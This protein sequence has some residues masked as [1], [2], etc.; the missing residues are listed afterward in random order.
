MDFEDVI[1]GGIKTKYQYI[2]VDQDDFGLT[3]AELLFA[4]DKLLN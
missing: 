3:D 2:N 1:A 4:D